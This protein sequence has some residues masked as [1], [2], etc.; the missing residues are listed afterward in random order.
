[1]KKFLLCAALVAAFSLPALASEATFE[2]TL[3]VKGQATLIINTGSGYIHLTRG[4]DSQIQIHGRVKSSGWDGSEA[5]VKEIAEHPP[6]EQ[7]GDIIRIGTH[8]E[9]WNHITID[10][11]V[12]LPANAILNAGTGSG[13]IIVEGVGQNSVIETGSGNIKANG[14]TGSLRAHTG[15]GNI[16]GDL[17]GSGE[18]QAGTGS[19]NVTLHGVHGGLKAETGSGNIHISGNPEHDWKLETGSGSVV[20]EVGHAAFDLNAETGSGSIQVDQ[21]STF[22][23][24]QEKHHVR[25]KVNGGG[26]AVKVETGSGDIRVR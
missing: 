11:D 2:R 21:P 13:D 4:N 25:S 3:S 8:N 24:S 17:S 18:V 20:L 10:Y 7:T 22:E 1:M 16:D 15:S 5:K 23:G 6:I 9:H 19:G 14:L 12:Q 26:P